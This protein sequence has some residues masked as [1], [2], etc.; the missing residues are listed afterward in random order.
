[1][2]G[3]HHIISGVA[4]AVATNEAVKLA[5]SFFNT[6]FYESL[7][8]CSMFD[9][10]IK[11]DGIGQVFGAILT[12]IV[13]AGL[14][15]LGCL[16]PDID[17]EHSTLGRY[18]HLPVAHRTWT[19]TVWFIAL[20][21]IPAIFVVPWLAWLAYGCFLHIFLDSLSKGGICWFYPISQYKKW[22]SGAQIKKN[23]WIYL[24]RTGEMSETILTGFFVL[25]GAGLLVYDIL[26]TLGF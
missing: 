22:T 7:H 3:K 24:Y 16:L 10:I 18:F 13:C 4:L 15:L 17:Q 8:R 20:F 19:H 11:S 6:D 25:L 5:T 23:H 1:M 9:N 26:L 14:F 2:N 21:A 12:T